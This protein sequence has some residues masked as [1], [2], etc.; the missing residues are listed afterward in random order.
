LLRLPDESEFKSVSVVRHWTPANSVARIVTA[1]GGGWG[2][3]LERDPEKVRWDVLEEYISVTAAREAYGVA[4]DPV[5]FEVD[6]EGTDRLRAE[7]RQRQKK[8]SNQ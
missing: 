8:D 2:D 5:T 7:L 6:I 3:P 4:L 1:G